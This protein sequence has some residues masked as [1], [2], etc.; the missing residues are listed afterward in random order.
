MKT[1]VDESLMKEVMEPKK[2]EVILYFKRNEAYKDKF[3]KD[4]QRDYTSEVKELLKKNELESKLIPNT[5]F[6]EFMGVAVESTDEH[7]LTENTNKLYNILKEKRIQ[8]KNIADVVIDPKGIWFDLS[9]GHRKKERELFK[10]SLGRDVTIYGKNEFMVKMPIER[11]VIPSI[12]VALEEVRRY[13][14]KKQELSL[15]N[16]YNI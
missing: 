8:I 10:E 7:K 9:Q 6:E 3:G 11:D 14:V 13:I 5:P 1:N 12:I 16:Y 4:K 2:I 15:L